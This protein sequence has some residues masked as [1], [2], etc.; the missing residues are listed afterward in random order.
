[1]AEFPGIAHVAVTVS[2]LGRSTAWYGR[3]FDAK[4]VLEVTD[5]ESPSMPGTPRRDQWPIQ[6]RSVAVLR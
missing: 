1:M 5:S 6:G 4:P 3:L 2:D